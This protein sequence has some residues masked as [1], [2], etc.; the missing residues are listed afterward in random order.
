[1][2]KPSYNNE[3]LTRYLLGSLPEDQTEAFDELSIADDEFAETLDAAE[4]DLVDAYVQ[5]E[6]R[7]AELKQFELHYLASPMGGENVGFARALRILGEKKDRERQTEAS[8]EETSKRSAKTETSAWWSAWNIFTTPRLALQW[9]FAAMALLFLVAGGW[10]AFENARLR[11]QVSQNKREALGTSE[12]EPQVQPLGANAA[13][14]S[15]S[16][17]PLPKDERVPVVAQLNDGGRQVTLDKEGK[18]SGV[19]LL[20]P[21]YQAM[22]REA[23]ATQRFEKSSLLAGLA[24]PGSSLM[25]DNQGNSFSVIEPIG[26]VVLS[27]RPTF[28]WSQLSGAT[29]YVVEVYDERFNLTASSPQGNFDSWTLPKPLRRGEVYSWQVKALKDSQELKSPS[30][31]APQA[32]FRILDQAK[33]HEL[34]QARSSYASSHL[35]IALLCSRAGLLDEAEQELQLLQKENPNSTVISRWLASVR[36]VRQ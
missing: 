33:A 24:R 3:T 13:T 28:R 35:L 30:P 32:K 26:K 12:P 18:L 16:S 14:P 19:D 20:P 9:G 4:K 17:K 5:E 6:L 10:L 31:P 34:A 27:D 15:A 23:L 7:G 11:Q 36:A 1:M 8:T 22:L 29:G 25:S 21:A 2:N